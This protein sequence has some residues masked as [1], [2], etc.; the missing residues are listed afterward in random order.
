MRGRY[1]TLKSEKDPLALHV[2]LERCGNGNYM[3]ATEP[4]ILWGVA[5]AAPE[6]T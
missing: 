3:G 4:R 5:P 1:L 6:P 2:I